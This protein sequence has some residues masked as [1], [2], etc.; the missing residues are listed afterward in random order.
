GQG[1]ADLVADTGVRVARARGQGWILQRHEVCT[2]F[3][4]F[5]WCVL[6]LCYVNELPGRWCAVV[7]K[8]SI[9]QRGLVFDNRTKN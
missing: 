8:S 2:R 9:R 3:L 6:G 5:L 1:T 7:K 4:K